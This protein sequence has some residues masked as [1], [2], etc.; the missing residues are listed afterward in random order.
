MRRHSRMLLYIWVWIHAC[1]NTHTQTQHSIHSS[2]HVK[3]EVKLKFS[4]EKATKVRRGVEVYLYSFFNLGARWCGWSTS[5][6]GRLTPRNTRYSLYG[7]LGGP[8]GRSERVRKITPPL[9]R[10]HKHTHINT[11][12]TNRI[13]QKHIFTKYNS[14]YIRLHPTNA[15]RPRTG[16]L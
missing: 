12:I 13:L 16:T 6:P 4:L 7:R 5:R 10:I 9:I 2:M 1:T 15:Y 3:L 14:K 11:A 8:Q